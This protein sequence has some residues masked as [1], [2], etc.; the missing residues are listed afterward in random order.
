[1]RITVLIVAASAAFA[2]T[3]CQKAEQKA[4]P[5]TTEAVEAAGVADPA[6]AETAQ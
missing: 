3:A 2:L 4:D 1:M 6:A 5:G